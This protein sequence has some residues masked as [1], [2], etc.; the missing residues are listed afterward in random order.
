MKQMAE[1]ARKY[2]RT[3][4]G[5]YSKLTDYGFE[6]TPYPKK[7]DEQPKSYV[8]MLSYFWNKEK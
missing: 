5:T 7:K 1:L 2:S 4:N 6:F 3:H 8:V